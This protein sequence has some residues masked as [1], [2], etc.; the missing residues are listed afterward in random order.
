MRL[1]FCV[2]R[3]P[4][5]RVCDGEAKQKQRGTGI[6]VLCRY[7]AIRARTAGRAAKERLQ[8]RRDSRCAQAVARAAKRRAG[9]QTQR[10]CRVAASEVLKTAQMTSA[11]RAEYAHQNSTRQPEHRPCPRPARPR[12]GRKPIGPCKRSKAAVRTL[13][14]LA[15]MA[16]TSPR[17]LAKRLSSQVAQAQSQRSRIW[18]SSESEE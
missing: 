7:V 10:W 18:P 9:Q 4:D 6:N 8:G 3:R 12:L 5:A 16:P 13:K 15:K 1:S 14:W 11:G 17:R 2:G